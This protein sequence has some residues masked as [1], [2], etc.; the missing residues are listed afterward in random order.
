MR[1]ETK[2]INYKDLIIEE[3][4]ENRIFLKKYVD[5]LTGKSNAYITRI[6]LSK[7]KPG[8]YKRHN[9]QWIYVLDKI[10]KAHLELII[11]NIRIGNRL[12]LHLYHNLN[13]KCPYTFICSDDVV[14]YEAYKT[15]GIEKVP[16]IVLGSKKYLEESAFVQKKFQDV[17]NNDVYP[18]C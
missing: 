2:I 17:L 18:N 1:P 12:P 15:L 3:Y 13:N 5:F 6:S 10:N 7:I 9:N 16:A 11:Q 4:E 8:F 14:I